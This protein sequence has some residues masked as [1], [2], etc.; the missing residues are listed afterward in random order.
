MLAPIV[1][2]KALEHM[3]CCS[4]STLESLF[5]DHFAYPCYSGCGHIVLEGNKH[6][7]S[8]IYDPEQTRVVSIYRNK[9]GPD[10]RRLLG[11][12]SDPRSRANCCELIP[13]QSTSLKL[14]VAFI[15][16]SIL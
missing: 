11:D 15:V 16:P 7:A 3:N 8:S 6:D 2:D 13:P 5:S 4:H 1:S 9:C 10:T 14:V 12:E